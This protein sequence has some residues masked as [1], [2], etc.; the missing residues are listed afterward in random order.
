[1]VGWKELLSYPSYAWEVNRHFDARVIA[2]RNMGN[3]RG[4]FTGW[5]RAQATSPR[6]A[7]AL[8][9]VSLALLAWAAWQWGPEDA[10]DITRWNNG[11]CIALLS[12]FLVSYHSYNHDMSILFL[13]ALL[14]ADRLLQGRPE[15]WYNF[16]LK[17]GLG[18][19]FFS[20]LYLILTLHYSHQNLFA[21][22]LLELV[23]TLA[24]WSAS[25][26]AGSGRDCSPNLA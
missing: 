1:L 14:L 17:L 15:G 23:G 22:V 8:L 13:P 16:A 3:L 24:A 21:L 9:A 25:L 4:L 10:C 2:P 19:M 12:T 7:L 20:P 18:L 5:S 26:K 6:V 11:F